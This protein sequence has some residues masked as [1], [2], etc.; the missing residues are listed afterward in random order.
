M[1]MK[2]Y[3]TG[4]ITSLLMFSSLPVLSAEIVW[5]AVDRTTGRINVDWCWTTYQNCSTG[6]ID[7]NTWMC[8]AMPK[9]A[10]AR[11]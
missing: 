3:I 7:M 11:Q 4:L 10:G 9:P 6:S 2:A 8:I 5:C 1:K